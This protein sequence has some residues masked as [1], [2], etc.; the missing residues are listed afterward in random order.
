[1]A[2]KQLQKIGNYNQ[3]N[4]GF[5]FLYF[6]PRQQ[7]SSLL[8]RL[9]PACQG[10]LSLAQRELAWL[11][12]HV[13]KTQPPALQ[14]STLDR[15]IE[16][17]VIHHKPLQYILGTQP[18]LDLDI[19]TEPPTLIPRWETEEWVHRLQQ[20]GYLVQGDRILD[21][22]TGTGC[23]ALALKANT[24]IDISDE[25][26]AL[27]RRNAAKHGQVL[28]VLKCDV[29]DDSVAALVADHDV[30]VANPPYVTRDQYETLEKDVKHWEDIRALVA[31]QEGLAVHHRIVD[32]ALQAKTKVLA[33]EIG[34]T[35]QVD[36]LRRRLKDDYAVH[37]WQDLRCKDR[38][39]LATKRKIIQLVKWGVP[40]SLAVIG[41]YAYQKQNRPNVGHPMPFK[42]SENDDSEYQ[43][44]RQEWAERNNGIGLRDV[45]RSGGGV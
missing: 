45:G 4:R 35:A 23:I 7:L 2:T 10:D 43:K 21:I 40:I 37:V 38:L 26:V 36:P 3:K 27:A 1:M 11:K 34:G 6:M 9:V 25:A 42:S 33:M 18:F 17:R 30:V 13:Q 39:V 15:Y 31:D 28:S 22:C 44:S 16:E 14:T 5:F 29:F 20:S 19:L 41:Y 32:L 12:E 24:A 8:R